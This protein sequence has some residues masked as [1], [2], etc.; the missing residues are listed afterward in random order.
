M[1]DRLGA[2]RAEGG[3][4]TRLRLAVVTTRDRPGDYADCVDAISPQVDAV[5]PVVHTPSGYSPPQYVL[6]IVQ[7]F[8]IFEPQDRDYSR[9]GFYAPDVV[10]MDAPYLAGYGIYAEDPP[11][12]SRMW[13]LGLEMAKDYSRRAGL[14]YDVAILND[15]AVVPSDWFAR[16]TAEMRKTGAAAGCVRRVDDPRMS[17]F[18]FVLNGDL[19]LRADEQF[20]WWYGDDDLQRQAEAA[21]GVAF[22]AGEGVEHRCPNST[23]VGVLREVADQD[24]ARYYE[25]WR[26]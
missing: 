4:V 24:R 21:G 23:T 1:G 22:A 26:L 2:R 18:A 5:I 20:Q 6:D 16:V 10:V 25:K 13:N 8:D 15:D 12:I 9:P 14:P 11:N 17:G 3:P 7:G 19:D